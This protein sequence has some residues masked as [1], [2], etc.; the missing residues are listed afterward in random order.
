MTP[1]QIDK[2]KRAK[3]AGWTWVDIAKELGCS[4]D[5]VKY[6]VKKVDRGSF[7]DWWRQPPPSTE[8]LIKNNNQLRAELENYKK[9]SVSVDKDAEIAKLRKE[10][11]NLQEYN[12]Y[13]QTF[14]SND[15]NRSDSKK[16][17]LKAIESKIEAN[18]DSR[19][20]RG[21][22]FNRVTSL[23][24]DYFNCYEDSIDHSVGRSQVKEEEAKKFLEKVKELIEQL[25]KAIEGKLGKTYW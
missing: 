19:E 12:P 24:R 5:S 6:Y 10:V 22:N 1:E 18:T 11:L 4:P 9:A 16:V 25:E 2:A 3:L 7:K 13:L 14:K 20:G 15:L 23:L 8:D 17:L 21:Y